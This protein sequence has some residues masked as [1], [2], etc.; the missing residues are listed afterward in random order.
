MKKILIV[1]FLFTLCRGIQGKYLFL[2]STNYHL[3]TVKKI[4]YDQNIVQVSINFS[5]SYYI[6]ANTKL[7]RLRLYG[8]DCPKTNQPFGKKAQQF[9]INSI[10]NKTIKNK[11]NMIGDKNENTTKVNK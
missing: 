7:I 5:N 6:H 9:I 8:I 10:L 4:F 3:G 11:S 1:I 2:K